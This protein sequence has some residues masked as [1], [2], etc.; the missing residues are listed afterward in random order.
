MKCVMPWWPGL[1]VL[2][3]SFA[4]WHHTEFTIV[5]CSAAICNAI[6]TDRSRP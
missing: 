5:L 2:S 4:L 3:T 1:L 6:Y